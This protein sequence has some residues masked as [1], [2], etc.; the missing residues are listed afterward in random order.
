MKLS[1]GVIFGGKS[2]EHELSILTAIQAMD[3]IDKERYEVVPIYIAEDL[4]I[5][6]GGMLRY[7]D[8]YKDF[9]LINRYAKK[10]NLINKNGKFILQTTG[11]FKKEYKEIHLAFP[12]VHGKNTEDGG[13]V[14]YLETLGIPFVGSDIY[15][16]SACQDKVFAKQILEAN[17]LPVTDYVHFTDNDYRMDKE[18]IFKKIDKLSY[19]LIVKPARLGSSIGIELVNRKEE[20]ESSLAKVMQKD[21]RVLVEEYISDRREYNMAVLLS[22]GKLIGSVIEEID[23]DE[24][25]DYYDKYRKDDDNDDTYKRIYPAS[26][27]KTLTEEIEKTS[28]EAYKILS[29]NG[30]ARI[31]Y[32]YDNKKK[33]LYI[34]EINTIP[35]FFSHHL[36]EDKNIDYR[37]LLG[38]MIKEA[39]DKIHKADTMI[40]SV[41]D[42]FFKNVTSKDIKDMK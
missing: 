9:N 11:L 16:S 17:N 30:V 6:S 18:E 1:I 13:I 26:I 33:K 37:E 20:L 2:L 19:P 29:L 3:N 36:F 27:S 4:T 5:Y 40:K 21:D 41:D 38:I 39:I 12:M 15:A 32:I 7:I 35:N 22:K 10:V 42:E 25:C 24:P 8:S 14:G 23:K 34:N 31:D 28:K